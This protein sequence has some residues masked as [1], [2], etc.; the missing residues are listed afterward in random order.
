M[1]QPKL[2]LKLP[3]MPDRDYPF[4]DMRLDSTPPVDNAPGWSELLYAFAT[5]VLMALVA[6]EVM[7]F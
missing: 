6:V 2:K 4:S 3:A 1:G 7:L 5:V